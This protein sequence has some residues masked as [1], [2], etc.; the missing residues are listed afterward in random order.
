MEV[1]QLGQ[2][3]LLLLVRFTEAGELLIGKGLEELAREVF[4]RLNKVN[5]DRKLPGSSSRSG[6][7]A[8][9]GTP[10]LLE[11]YN[12][13]QTEIFLK[14]L[15]QGPCLL[16]SGT[17]SGAGVKLRK[18]SSNDA[19]GSSGNE[20]YSSFFSQDD[21]GG[22]LK[23]QTGICMGS[24][25]FVMVLVDYWFRSKTTSLSG[26]GGSGS[27]QLSF[28]TVVEEYAMPNDVR[29][30]AAA[31]ASAATSALKSTP[32]TKSKTK[33][34][35]KAKSRVSARGRKA[36]VSSDSELS[37]PS[38]GES[39]SSLELQ[40]TSVVDPP[41][42]AEADQETLAQW[43][44]KDL[45]QVEWTV[46][47]IEVLVWSWIEARGIRRDEIEQT[48]LEMVLYPDGTASQQSID[49]NTTSGWLAMSKLLSTLGGTL[50]SRWENLESVIEAA[51]MGED[52]CLR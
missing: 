38:D 46:M 16:D 34:K 19:G 3:I 33:A 35:P 17:G 41:T 30:A 6:S 45:E 49:E 21:Y 50:Q 43:N 40:L 47:M 18:E 28:R 11:R 37:L 36:S 27:S 13:D 2:Q 20:E 9:A 7:G 52:L 39:E 12:L 51:I 48:G 5:K 10:F 23:S 8:G 25:V 44:A 14:S 29:L 26:A 1:L 24:S 32:K 42:V 4:S 22:V 31:A 15:I